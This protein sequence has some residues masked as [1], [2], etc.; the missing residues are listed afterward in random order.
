M[1]WAARGRKWD[2]KQGRL[3]RVAGQCMGIASQEAVKRYSQLCWTTSDVS[4]QAVQR[5]YCGEA[6]EREAK[7]REFGYLSFSFSPNH[8]KH[9]S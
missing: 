5:N 8:P 1:A 4:R 3:A 2:A 6:N 7:E 9:A